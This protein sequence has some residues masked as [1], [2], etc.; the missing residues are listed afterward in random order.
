MEWKIRMQMPNYSD[1]MT[2]ALIA[3]E[4]IKVAKLSIFSK[5]GFPSVKGMRIC[6]PQYL[7]KSFNI[8][9]FVQL[10]QA[11]VISRL[12]YCNVLC[13]SHPACAFIPLWWDWSSTSPRVFS[14]HW[15]P[16]AICVKFSSSLSQWHLVA[17]TQKA[18]SHFP[19]PSLSL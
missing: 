15:L 2:W 18:Q 17:P 14:L 12:D 8:Q 13:A 7:Q 9:P 11:L 6:T 10:V 16:I 4:C 19:K 3:L 5:Y 1:S